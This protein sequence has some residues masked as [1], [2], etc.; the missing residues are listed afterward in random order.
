MKKTW[1]GPLFVIVVAIIVL[2]HWHAGD[3]PPLLDIPNTVLGEKPSASPAEAG[4]RASVDGEWQ[5]LFNGRDLAGWGQV[6]GGRSFVRDGVLCL[7]NDSER[8]TGYL[9]S[10]VKARNFRA[11]LR[12]Q[13]PT[14]DSGFYFRARFDPHTPTEVIGPQVQLNFEPNSG[15]GGLFEPQ[16]RGWLVKPSPEVNARLLQ[17]LDWVDCDVEV[18][19]RHILVR[20]NGVK[21]VDFTDANPD[22]RYQEAG[23]FALQ[24]HGG[25]YCD[26]RFQLIQAQ[27]LN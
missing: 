15:L 2:W 19:E 10:T 1:F 6:G 8:R 7:A 9:V 20:V 17:G 26:A 23:F 16:G 12:C 11:R 22:N 24:I 14:G 5:S 18:V 13:V 25:G 3:K 21:T 4:V 27:I